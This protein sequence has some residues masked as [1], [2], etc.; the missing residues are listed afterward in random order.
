M[1]FPQ[2]LASLFVSTLVAAQSTTAAAKILTNQD[3]VNLKTSITR[4][5]LSTGEGPERNLAL[6]VRLSFHDIALFNGKT[7]GPQG[8]L[9]AASIQAIPGN[10]GLSQVIQDLT[11]WVQK[12]LP[13]IHYPAGDVFSF[14]GKIATELAF[15]CMNIP[16]GF[17]RVECAANPQVGPDNVIP[18]AKF[19]T[20][21]EIDPITDNYGLNPTEMAVLLAG[22]HGMA[23][24]RVEAKSTDFSD[25]TFAIVNSGFD[26]LE[27]TFNQPWTIRK[28][29]KG[30]NEF[31][32]QSGLVRLP[33]DLLWFPTVAKASGGV[34]D[35]KANPIEA[36]MKRFLSGGRNNFDM[37][38][39]SVYA[40]LLNVGVPV[41]SLIPFQETVTR[42][43]CVN[44]PAMP[45]M[46]PAPVVTTSTSTTSSASKTSISTSST[47]PSTATSITSA[48]TTSITSATTTP[49][50]SATASSQST[51]S[52]STLA[53]NSS[54]TQS[55][56][57]STTLSNLTSSTFTS[58]STLSTL[59]RT[60]SDGAVQTITSIISGT[61]T[62]TVPLS[63]SS[64]ISIPSVKPN[65]NPSRSR[66]I[67]STTQ[68]P[69]TALPGSSLVNP[70]SAA[71]YYN[72]ASFASHHHPSVLGLLL[73]TSSSLILGIL[74]VQ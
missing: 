33:I 67:P 3:Y 49:I 28:S 48:T 12:E 42:G 21:A 52:S 29:A 13:G 45:P 40:K 73:C 4:F 57:T 54:I 68:G 31:V 60:N 71:T 34:A 55:T 17:G 16:W 44:N 2:V 22:A 23:K 63:P 70:D 46:P 6:L 69:I 50:T 19:T 64:V 30:Q 36:N 35:R 9:V 56:F 32:G 25:G 51:V 37:S 7:F 1:M 5:I 74:F 11:A 53:S 58:F 14:A 41:G 59:T 47:F 43:T 38:Y 39:Q 62:T 27:K 66:T 26:W 20:T 10:A 65:G 18:D 72:I 24:A 61:A 15:P 8:C